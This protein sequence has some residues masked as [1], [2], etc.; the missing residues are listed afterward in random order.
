MRLLIL[1][2]SHRQIREMSMIIEKLQKD[3]DAILHAGDFVD[4]ILVFQELYKNKKFYYVK[5]N[6][7][8]G[9]EAKKELIIEMGG[10]RIFMTHGHEYSVKYNTDRIIYA[11]M[12]KQAD[13]CIFGHT[14]CP[15][16]FYENGI[17]I[18]NPGSISMPRGYKY[19]TYGII[20]IEDKTPRGSIVAIEGSIIKPA[21]NI[22][23]Y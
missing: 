4:D 10:V 16:C 5:G 8:F 12:E 7:D 3:C 14:H 11:A 20:N 22:Q 6:C 13:V 17:L 18:M 2:E 9:N 1:S 23:R 21:E 19:P 15:T